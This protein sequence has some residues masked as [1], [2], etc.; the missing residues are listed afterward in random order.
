[1]LAQ[2][3]SKQYSQYQLAVLASIEAIRKDPNDPEHLHK[4]RTNTRRIRTLLKM[5]KSYLDPNFFQEARTLYKELIEYTNPIRDID[6]FLIHLQSLSLP[7]RMSGW[8][9]PVVQLLQKQRKGYYQ[10]LLNNLDPFETQIKKLFLQCS[11]QATI[12]TKKALKKAIKKQKKAV[13]RTKGSDLHRIR[14]AYKYL[15]YLYELTKDRKKV[16]QLKRIQDLLGEYHDYEVACER[17]LEIGE[18]IDE[19]KALMALGAVYM[20]FC[21]RKSKIYRKVQTFTK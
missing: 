7:S 12:S 8:I 17:I 4:L 2:M 1:M 14:I 13:E 20:I 5:F 21:K 9:D 15:R 19:K 16:R 11:A 18:Q 3:L 10:E 6:V